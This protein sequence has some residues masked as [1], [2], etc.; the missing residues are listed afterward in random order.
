MKGGAAP[1]QQVVAVEHLRLGGSF[2]TACVRV[3]CENARD[4]RT[5]KRATQTKIYKDDGKG[6]NDV[7][8][9]MI[10]SFLQSKGSADEL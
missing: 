8:S 6:R 10:T 4:A 3:S 1:A 5:T 9:P 2:W 7:V